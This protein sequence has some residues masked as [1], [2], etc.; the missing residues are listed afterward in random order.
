MHKIALKIFEQPGLFENRLHENFC[1]KVTRRKK[2]NYGT[3]IF[4]NISNLFPLFWN[5][6]IG[7]SLIIGW[8]LELL[9]TESNGRILYPVLII[10]YQ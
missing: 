8:C 10:I 3:L 1:T 7:F 9:G 4:F 6:M 5:L 2:A